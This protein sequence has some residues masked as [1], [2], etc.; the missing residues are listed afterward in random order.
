[1]QAMLSLDLVGEERLAQFKHAVDLGDHLAVTGE[2]IT[3][4][5]A[6]SSSS[7]WR[8]SRRRIRGISCHRPRS[9]TPGRPCL[10]CTRA[11]G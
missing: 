10:T 7:T 5:T 9:P 4:R 3:A 2:V 8:A 11:P 1:L 6:I